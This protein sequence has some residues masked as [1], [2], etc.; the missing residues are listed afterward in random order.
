[1]GSGAA[2][3]VRLRFPNGPTLEDVVDDRVVLFIT[4][5]RVDLP[6]AAE[7]LDA[8]GALLATHSAF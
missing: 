5:A 3:R 8:S 1:M 7:I 2:A 6:A 4:N